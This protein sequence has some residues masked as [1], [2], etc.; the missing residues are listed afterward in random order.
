MTTQPAP[1]GGRG[2]DKRFVAILYGLQALGLVVGITFL[3][4]LVLAYLRREDIGD[5]RLQAHLSWQIRTFWWGLLWNIIAG[6]TVW[7]FGLGAV[8]GVL[9]WLWV[10]YRVVRGL[11]RL[12]SGLEI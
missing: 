1:Y 8:L 10:L 12:N 11:L 6:A 4:A 3:V 9:V 5:H 2:E 7:F